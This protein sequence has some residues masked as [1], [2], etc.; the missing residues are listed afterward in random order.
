[1]KNIFII[2]FLI[3]GNQIYSQ[4]VPEVIKKV[5]GF[6]YT[7]DDEKIFKPQGTGFFV[8]VVDEARKNGSIYFATA[9]HVIQNDSTQLDT[10][11]IRLNDK[12]GASQY[13]RIRIIR[14]GLQKNVFFHPDKTVDLAVFTE[15]PSLDDFDFKFLDS[16]LILSKD[17]D[18]GLR[19]HEGAEVYFTGMFTPYTGGKSIYPITR[20]G[21]VALVTDEKVMWANGLTN[22]YLVEAT[23]Y[24]G[25][26][27]SPV[28]F[29]LNVFDEDNS[30]PTWEKKVKFAGVMSGFF[31]Q[32]VPLQ[33][34]KTGV[35]PTSVTNL[36]IAAVVPS[37]YLE[38]IIFGDELTKL[39]GF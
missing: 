25:N 4:A 8:S 13:V 19:V 7:S 24:W 23:T 6:I 26:S 32:K 10:I 22:L 9:K 29:I 20:F 5:V 2:L 21:R 36:G 17:S 27:G 38:E 30:K 11:Y 1:M 14:E 39:R 34:V 28:F 33:Y 16:E 3:L 37:Y 35:L 31:N 15:I 12:I 18:N